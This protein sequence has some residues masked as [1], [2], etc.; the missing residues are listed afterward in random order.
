VEHDI[1]L[2]FALYDNNPGYNTFN[3]FR[4]HPLL[5]EIQENTTPAMACKR[6]AENTKNQ[7]NKQEK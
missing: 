5:K 7:N 4:S 1:I 3:D 2:T 6:L